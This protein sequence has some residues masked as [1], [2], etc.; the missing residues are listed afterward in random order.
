M[1]NYD[2]YFD[3]SDYD[4][5]PIDDR[6]THVSTPK[7]T[8][9]YEG[10]DVM[11]YTIWPFNEKFDTLQEAQYFFSDIDGD[12]SVSRGWGKSSSGLYTVLT[13]RAIRILDPEGD[14]VK[15]VPIK[16]EPGKLKID[17]YDPLD[18]I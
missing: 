4:P 16:G 11:K 12:N 15:L 9:E 2:D 8:V 5:D 1:P 3:D 17:N 18:I 14:E 13:F 10:R 7:Y 6:A